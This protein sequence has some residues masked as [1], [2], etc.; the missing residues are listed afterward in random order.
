MQI[1]RKKMI[2]WTMSP[3]L[4]LVSILVSL[5]VAIS[6]VPE[7]VEP[8]GAVKMSS[9]ALA[10][11]L[12]IPALVSLFRSPVSLF[13]PVSVTA[14]SP[15]YWILLDAIQGSY[16]LQGVIQSE[17]IQAYITIA[18]FSAG[19][20][21]AASRPPI[22]IPQKIWQSATIHLSSQSLFTI[23]CIAFGASFFRFAFPCNFDVYVMLS[24]F[25]GIR[26]S[27][28]WSRGLEG[29]WDAF[30]DHLSYFGYILPTLFVLIARREGW[31]SHRSVLTLAFAVVIVALQ[32]VGGGRRII[33]VMVGAAVCTWLLSQPKPQWKHLII[34]LATFLALLFVMQMILIFRNVGI[35]KAFSE[36]ASASFSKQKS[37][38][39]DDNFLRLCQL[40]GII[41]EQHPYTT[42]RWVLWVAV[43]PIPR[44]FWPGKPNT[45]GFSLPDFLGMKGVSLSMS[46]IGELYMAYGF[47][48]CFFGGVIY[49]KLAKTLASVLEYNRSPGS[50]VI[51]SA[52][53]L[54]LFAGMR[55]GIELIL[56]SYVLLGW[57]ALV[58]LSMEFLNVKAEEPG[59]GIGS[60]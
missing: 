16:E 42:W 21:I 24:A 41:P 28:P 44:V 8:A 7:N 19:V 43:R 46:T 13:H 20:W 58:I 1:H 38:H 12:A 11:G 35:L 23:A 27:A 17:V 59:R 6:F 60:S 47:L 30:I 37:L 29:G 5:L 56:M 57:I 9:I 4:G 49:G 31:L 14:A 55:S 40:T 52:G 34:V 51:F 15:I 22:R 32:S 54:A 26:W 50:I 2:D 39:I 53:L 3:S 25:D 45:P 18:L 10:I 33:G 48:G 36:D